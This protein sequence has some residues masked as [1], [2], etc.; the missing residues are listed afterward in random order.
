MPL[1]YDSKPFSFNYRMTAAD[2]PCPM[3]HR[4]LTEKLCAVIEKEVLAVTCAC[5]KF[6]DYALGMQF[7]VGT[8]RKPLVPLLSTTDLSSMPPRTLRFRTRLMRYG[9]K[10]TNIPGKQQITADVLSRAPVS[11]PK[12]SNFDLIDE[13]KS[14]TSQIVTGL[15]S[16]AKRLG[17]IKQARD[18]DE[19]CVQMKISCIEGWPTYVPHSPILKSC[20]ENKGH[21]AVVDGLLLFYDRIVI[22][23]CL[24]LDI[25]QSIHQGHLGITKCQARMSV[26]WPCVTTAFIELVIKCST[27]AKHRPEPK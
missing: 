3:P 22:P 19:K 14:F 16:T 4:S 13:V 23:R 27:C 2:D 1:I 18:M 11:K 21:L 5:E 7:T 20:R 15:P 24:R 12:Q 17:E 8:D 25:L 6:S 10:V 9:P 26:W